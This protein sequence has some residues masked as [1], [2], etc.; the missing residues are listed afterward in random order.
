MEIALERERNR[1]WEMRRKRGPADPSLGFEPER[2]RVAR[3]S[4]TGAEQRD[5]HMRSMR[6]VEDISPP[7]HQPG[8][9]YES[10]LNAKR[11]VPPIQ[12]CNVLIHAY[13][14][15]CLC[16]SPLHVSFLCMLCL[17]VLPVYLHS[18]HVLCVC[19]CLPVCLCLAFCLSGINTNSQNYENFLNTVEQTS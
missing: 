1:D 10:E 13:I 9:Y 6:H 15:L 11:C 12:Q 19:V 4:W 3:D 2:K 14:L 17:S 16:L 7:H 18:V 8:G 5:Q